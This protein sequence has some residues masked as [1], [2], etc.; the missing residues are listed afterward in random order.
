MRMRLQLHYAWIVA[1]IAFLALLAAA[2]VRSTPGVMILPLEEAFGWERTVVTSALAI[3][4]ALYGLCGPF[5]AAFMERYGIKRVMLIALLAL[6]IGMGLSVWMSTAWQ[7]VLLWGLI[8]GIGS[9]FT[10][11]VLGAVIARRWFKERQGLVVGIFTASGATGQLVFLP[12]LA[13]IAE[14]SSWQGAVT[15]TAAAAALVVVLVFLFMRERPSDVSVLPYGATEPQEEV[16]PTGSPFRSAMQGLRIGV[17]SRPFW[18]LAGSFFIC[19]ASTNGLIGSHFIPT[20]VEHGIPEV[21]AAGMLA[22]MGIFDM[23]GTTMSGWLSD[24]WDSRWLLFWYYGLRGLSLLFLPTALETGG[25]ALG[26]F[27]VFYGLDWV[28]TV[29]PTVKLANENFGA[30]SSIVFGWIFAAH[31]LGA[32][33][34]SL[35]GGYLR[36]W[37]G[38][39][40]LTF[41]TAGVVCLL[42]SGFVMGVKKK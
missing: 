24:R 11:S 30:Q 14:S 3:N 37:M 29:P 40:T 7:L 42:A 34:A 1:A 22:V 33:T 9:G 15:I 41:V 28:A 26:I 25:L 17:K 20:C 32:A 18:L 10:S 39:Y 8:V 2:G 36:T 21:T 27:V 31:Q 23:I 16:R 13:Q 6:T 5:A 12:V 19:G 35:G 4:L 38:D